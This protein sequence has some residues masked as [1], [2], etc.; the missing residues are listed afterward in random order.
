[1]KGIYLKGTAFCSSILP[2][3]N[4]VEAKELTTKQHNEMK[5]LKLSPEKKKQ[6]IKLVIKPRQFSSGCG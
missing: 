4:T 1:M 5:Y 2:N 3:N 6:P